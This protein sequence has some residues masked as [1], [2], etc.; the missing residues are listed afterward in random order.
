VSHQPE[1]K[2]KDCLNCGTNV[3][4]RFCQNCGQENIVTHQNFWSLTKHF[5]FDIFHFD[6]KFFDTLR[7]LL[8]KPGYVA[9]EY[10]RGKRVKFL[11]PIR[12]Y[13]FT[14]AIFFLVLFSMSNVEPSTKNLNGAVNL[15]NNERLKMVKEYRED[16]KKRP[17]DTIIQQKIAL[18]SDTSR[19]VRLADVL[20]NS[21]FE[22]NDKSYRSIKEYDSLQQLLPQNERDGWFIQRFSRKGIELNEKYKGDSDALLK[23]LLNSFI[24]K[25]PY[26]LF[27]SLPFFAGLLKLLYI[28][29]K[30]FY[31]SDHAVFTLY[32]YIFSF[33]ILLLIFGFINLG[34]RLNWSFFGWIAFVLIILWFVYLYKGMRNFYGQ[35]RVKTFIKFLLLDFTGFMLIAALFLFFFLFTAY[36]L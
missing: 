26:I 30:S 19:P 31:Y 12:M 3:Q 7:F 2:E 16:L 32:H 27:I 18:L 25:F 8:F 11:D 24:H 15:S 4:G 17:T 9:K 14:S 35:N 29:R 1:R 21:G 6:G 20:I 34:D 28:R 22:I 5:I 33:I 10:I 23:S 13:L 36:Q